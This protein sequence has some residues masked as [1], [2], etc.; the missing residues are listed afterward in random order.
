M[1]TVVINNIYLFSFLSFDWGPK[2]RC[3]LA[4]PSDF[5]NF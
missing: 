4:K 2:V 3:R 1:K 5:F